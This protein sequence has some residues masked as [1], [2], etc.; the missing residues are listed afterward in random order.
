MQEICATVARFTKKSTQQK[1]ES[2][3]YPQK[4]CLQMEA[5]DLNTHKLCYCGL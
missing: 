3:R 2:A 1:N 4:W 5:L